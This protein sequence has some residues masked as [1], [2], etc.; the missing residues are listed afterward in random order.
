MILFIDTGLADVEASK[1]VSIA[2]V[3]DCGQFEF[4]AERDPLPTGAAHFVCT[5]VY[6]LLERG[7]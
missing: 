7:A 4:Y 5:V 3:S 2:L 6:P 1:P